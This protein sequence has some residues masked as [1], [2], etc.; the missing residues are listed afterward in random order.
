MFANANA[1]ANANA[2][3]APT[4]HQVEAVAKVDRCKVLAVACQR[5]HRTARQ[6]EA[7]RKDVNMGLVL[8]FKKVP[9]S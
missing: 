9:N 1:N 6:I 8:L 4:V 5:H 3:T 2:T 7:A